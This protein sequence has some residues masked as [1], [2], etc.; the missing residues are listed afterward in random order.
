MNTHRLFLPATLSLALVLAAC[1]SDAD[2]GADGGANASDDPGATLA[3]LP[4][5]DDPSGG[6]VMVSGPSD[7]IPGWDVTMEID[8]DR[9]SGTAACNG[10]GG[11]VEIGDGTIAVTELSWT[12]MGCE[13]EIQQLE[14]D[15]LA[16]LSS[17][18]AFSVADDQLELDTPQGVW[19]FDRLEPVPTAELVGT[20]WVLDGY[21]DGD[22]VSNEIGMDAAFLEL[23]EDGTFV[24]ATNCRSLSGSWTET[25]SEIVFTDFAADGECPDAVASDLDNRIITVLGD[26]FRVE[27]DGALLTATS[28]GDEGLTFRAAG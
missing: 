3:P 22:S 12:E 4:S 15:F 26:G 10:Y 17:A 23:S 18:A 9:I 28:Q 27:V 24:G 2:T 8:G 19:A 16:S 11:T 7:P 25:G 5:I 1:G 20:T 14:Q 13:T 6:W 21:L